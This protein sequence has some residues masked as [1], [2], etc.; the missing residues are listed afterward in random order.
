MKIQDLIPAIKPGLILA[1]LNLLLCL[2]FAVCAAVAIGI[3]AAFFAFLDLP[4]PLFPVVVLGAV[5]FS[6]IAW[7]IF[8]ARLKQPRPVRIAVAAIGTSP[9]LGII[10]LAL[11]G[12]LWFLT[13]PSSPTVTVT[14][15][16][17]TGILA[18]GATAVCAVCVLWI[19]SAKQEEASAE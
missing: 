13:L 15:S 14:A 8:G 9:L 2:I 1:A 17:I 4:L 6:V 19:R 16:L 5:P 11:L 10:G 12:A 18:A 3:G 7:L